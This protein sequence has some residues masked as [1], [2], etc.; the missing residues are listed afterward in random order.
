MLNLGKF[1]INYPYLAT[2]KRKIASPA[3]PGGSMGKKDAD[4]KS[5]NTICTENS[6]NT[7]RAS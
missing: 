5:T 7:F 3:A 6:N 4:T 1:T 2:M